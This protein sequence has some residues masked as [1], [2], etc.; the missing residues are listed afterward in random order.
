MTDI[1]RLRVCLLLIALA[2]TPVLAAGDVEINYDLNG[3]ALND[4]CGLTAGNNAVFWA[5]GDQ[6]KVFKIE[7]GGIIAEYTL[8]GGDYDLHGVSFADGDHGWIVGYKRYDPNDPDSWRKGVVFRTITGGGG[9]GAWTPS[10]P[11][12]R[13]GINVPFLKVQAVNTNFVWVTCGDGYVLT[14]GDG[15]LNWNVVNKPGGA[16]DYSYLWGLWAFDGDRAWVASD[17]SRA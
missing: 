17:Q 11:P 7:N 4:V 5:V 15:G 14:S 16:G 12:V 1:T 2:V 3:P 13:D 9:S 6:G 10:C 8:E